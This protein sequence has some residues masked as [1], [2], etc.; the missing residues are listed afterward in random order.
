M[1]VDA[2]VDGSVALSTAVISR[3]LLPAPTNNGA[4]VVVVVVFLSFSQQA[5]TSSWKLNFRTETRREC[6]PKV[7]MLYVIKIGERAQTKDED[8]KPAPESI[9]RKEMRINAASNQ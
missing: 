2:R 6:Q 4:V 8:A 5:T 9:A 3:R 1:V 7:S